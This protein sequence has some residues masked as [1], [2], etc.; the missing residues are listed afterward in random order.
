MQFLATVP[1]Y[2]SL[3]REYL[4]A[5]ISANNENRHREAV[6]GAVAAELL[7]QEFAGDDGVNTQ[8]E[9]ILQR[10]LPLS[11]Q[12]VLVLG[13]ES[14][15]AR[16]GRIAGCWIGSSERFALTPLTVPLT[17]PI[18]HLCCRKVSSDGVLN[19]F[20]ALLSDQVEPNEIW[21]PH[22]AR[23]LVHRLRRDDDLVAMFEERLIASAPA[24]EKVSLPRLLA[25]ARGITSD[26][27][28][29]AVREIDCQTSAVSGPEVGTDYS[30][31]RLES[32]AQNLLEVIA[33]AA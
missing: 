20:L 13:T 16:D 25:A 4:V 11:H 14:R 1:N 28:A 21:D 15:C 17:L 22:M 7:G 10:P 18:W 9:A 3:L 23:P 5:G 32:V 19:N 29:W 2:R 8:L 33:A 24:S 6:L 27:R 30:T 31:G 12:D 26:V